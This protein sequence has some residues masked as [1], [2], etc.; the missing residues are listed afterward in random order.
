[1]NRQI[2]K[3]LY[4]IE[5]HLDESLDVRVLAKVAGYSQYHFCRIFKAS[6]GESVI[7]YATR[8]R[9]ERASLQVAVHNKS[10]IEIALE[11]GYD[12]PNGFNKAFKKIFGMTP[13]EYK[14]RQIYL[15]QSYK[16]KIMHT[17]KIV[18]RDK[19]YVVFARETG[20]YEKSSE[21][22]WKKLSK[23]LNDLGES[24]KNQADSINILINLDIKQ[25]ELLGICHDDPTVTAEENIR[26]DAAIAW[27]KKEIDFLHDKGLETKEIPGGKY[28][29]ISYKGNY[30]KA[31][32]SWIA[33]Y[34]WCEQNGCK[35]RDFPPFEKYLNTLDEVCEDELLTEIYVPIE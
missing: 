33:L 12:T 25:G 24:L 1:M 9:L 17:P 22:A 5:T 8:L 10:I 19:T 7:S 6:V 32:D 29:T 20:G 34:V 27:D 4:Y 16:D 35:F 30:A 11:A 26:Y 23:Q 3:V 21:I 18:N 31:M 13:T 28:A 2:Q 14:S 15:L